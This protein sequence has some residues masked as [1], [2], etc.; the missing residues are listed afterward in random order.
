MD[1]SALN[2]DCRNKLCQLHRLNNS[3]CNPTPVLLQ[4]ELEKYFSYIKEVITTKCVYHS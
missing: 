1:K 3:L 2:F 4:K